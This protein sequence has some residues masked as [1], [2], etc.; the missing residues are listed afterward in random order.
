MANIGLDRNWCG[1][2]FSQANWYAFGRMA[3]NPNQTADGIA[4][5]WLE[6]TFGTN[7]EMPEAMEQMMV[8]MVLSREAC[9]N[10]MMPLGLHHIFK[11]DHHMGPEPDGFKAEYPIEWCPV[12]YHKADKNGIGFDRTVATGT[13]ATAQYQDDVAKMFEDINQCPE[14]YLLWFHHVP[15]TYKLKNGRTLWENLQEKYD[16]GVQQVELTHND[17][18]RMKPYVDEQRWQEVEERL[19]E[20]LRDAREWRNV[21][22]RYFGSFANQ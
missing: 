22:L 19:Q 8:R 11:F 3:W 6:Q 2:H 10:Y 13:G 17:W 14:E 16:E 7:N 12:Y 20:Q 9:V 15:W 18:Q 4:L 21:C 1:H 5:E